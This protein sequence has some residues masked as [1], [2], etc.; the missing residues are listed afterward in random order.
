MKSSITDIKFRVR[1]AMYKTTYSTFSRKEP[2]FKC[3][4]SMYSTSNSRLNPSLNVHKKAVLPLKMGNTEYMEKYRYPVPAEAA[5]YMEKPVTSVCKGNTI[6]RSQLNPFH[7][8]IVKHMDPYISVS[9]LMIENST[10]VW[11]DDHILP[12][13]EGYPKVSSKFHQPVYDR[14]L[15]S[16]KPTYRNW[17]APPR[18]LR[19]TGV[20]SETN[21]QYSR[22]TNVC[23]RSSQYPVKC[24]IAAPRI[25]SSVNYAT[26]YD[27]IGRKWP[28]RAVVDPG[29]N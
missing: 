1:N 8:S 6:Q 27:H 15:L 24:D 20:Q 4:Y 5:V 13:R 19:N 3:S 26:E 18:S 25:M 23:S 21:Y 17:V 2:E 9:R 29:P 11:K 16:S 10:P 12:T 22:L 14:S 7:C 28:V